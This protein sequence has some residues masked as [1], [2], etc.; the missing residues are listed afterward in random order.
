[1]QSPPA[2]SYLKK[3][4]F[5]PHRLLCQTNIQSANQIPRGKRESV[6]LS[7]L[8][9]RLLSW[10]IEHFSTHDLRPFHSFIQLMAEEQN[11]ISI[12]S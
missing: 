9:R 12:S 10:D 3:D 4:A 2:L 5:R 6:L 8:K 11:F 7:E 1:M